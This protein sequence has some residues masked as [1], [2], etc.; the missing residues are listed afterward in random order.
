MSDQ[1][2]AN[3][4]RT[5]ADQAL[6]AAWKR[7]LDF[8]EASTAQKLHHSKIRTA[9]I[10]LGF[11]ASA[12][13]V[14]ISTK[15]TNPII[16]SISEG[17][18]VVLIFLP[19]ISAGLLTYASEFTPSLTWLAYRVGAELTRREIYLYRM[20]AGDYRGRTA[21]DQQS[22]VL[23]QVEAA[24]KRVNRVGVPDPY[25]QTTITD[26]PKAIV[27]RTSDPADDGFSP[28]SADQYIAYRVVPQKDWYIRKS[29]LDYQKTQRWRI[30]L[31]IVG[32]AS[33]GL[34]ALN[35][36]PF[37]AVTTALG[38]ALTTYMGL[39]MFGRNYPVYH[40]V[41]NSLELEMDRWSILTLE[42]QSDPAQIS[43]MVK[44]TEDIFQSESDQWTQQAIQAQQ[45]IEQSLSKSASG[46][47][48]SGLSQQSSTTTTN[49][50]VS[51]PDAATTVVAM[52]TQTVNADGTPPAPA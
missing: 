20:Q 18:R 3:T 9:I 42:Q 13:A 35:F 45:A 39:T 40:P 30:Y 21:L 41:A 43:A 8:D 31:L 12:L 49:L 36:A 1:V 7:F 16:G 23:A 14:A 19:I 27:G 24:N 51:Q 46:G 28:L 6:L 37:V 10:V 47:Q 32:F 22:L 34:A 25:L 50:T 44:H 4:I 29:H 15:D 48:Q 33:S 5:K 2:A 38:T 52:Q 26:V 17:L 11:A